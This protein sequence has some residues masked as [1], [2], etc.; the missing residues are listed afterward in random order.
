MHQQRARLDEASTSA[1]F[2]FMVMWV[3]AIGPLLY[4]AL[5][6]AAE[7]RA[8]A[9]RVT[10]MPRH[11]CGIRPAR[12]HPRAG[13]MIASAAAA[14]FFSEPHR[15]SFRSRRSRVRREQRRLVQIGE[16]IAQVAT[17]RQHRQHHVRG[18]GA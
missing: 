12:A 14:A 3:F 7:Q 17:C 15:G 1:P 11:A 4:L 9:A 2:T 16:P 10:M 8:A 13:D 5:F 18:G 6:L